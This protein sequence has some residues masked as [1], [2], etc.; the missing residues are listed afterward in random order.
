[1]AP[2]WHVAWSQRD[3]ES[4][5][6]AGTE[7]SRLFKPIA[8][9][10]PAFK[11]TSRRDA[12]LENRRIFAQLV[13]DYANA[14]LARDSSLVYSIMPELHDAFETTSSTLLPVYYP[15]FDG[16]VITLNVIL[17]THLPMSNSE[18][19]VG[20]T[21]TLVAKARGLAEDTIPAELATQKEEIVR[22]FERIRAVVDDMKGALD[23]GRMD[24]YRERAAVLQELVEDFLEDYI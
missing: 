12:F 5:Y 24:V 20:S 2:A 11:A 19:L 23:G 4:L 3:F 9:M 13:N 17:E 6:T 15:E 18:G 16:F 10:K 21:E 22:H 1:M 7:F 8:I 14:C